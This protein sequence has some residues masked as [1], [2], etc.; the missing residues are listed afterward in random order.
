MEWWRSR[1]DPAGAVEV[2]GGTLA[3]VV[4]VKWAAAYVAPH[5][6]PADSVDGSD[7]PKSRSVVMEERGGH[8]G[9][10]PS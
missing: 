4:E 6:R 1:D 10:R 3:G 7:A 9:D 2:S 5:V 8:N